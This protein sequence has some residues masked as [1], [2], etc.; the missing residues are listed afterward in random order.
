MAA[1][2]KGYYLLIR[3]FFDTIKLYFQTDDGRHRTRSLNQE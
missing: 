1:K 2:A 3:S